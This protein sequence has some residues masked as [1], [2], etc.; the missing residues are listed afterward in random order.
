MV[1]E[2]KQIYAGRNEQVRTSRIKVT[3]YTIKLVKNGCTSTRAGKTK[4]IIIKNESEYRNRIH[5]QCIQ[6][7]KA[8]GH[9][10]FELYHPTERLG[11]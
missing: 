4:T 8:V 9:I 5:E 3:T 2:N 7:Y 1:C 10:S 11:E 6:M